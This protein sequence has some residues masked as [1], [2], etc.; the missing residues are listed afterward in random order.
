M[1]IELEDLDAL[2]IGAAILGTGGGGDPYIGRL[3]LQNLIERTGPPSVIELDDLADDAFVITV[4]MSGSPSVMLEKLVD[5]SFGDAALRRFERL[6]G[7]RADAVMPVEIGGLNSLIPLMTSCLT[8]LPV[9]NGDGMGRA[10]PTLDRTSFGIAG[11]SAFPVVTVNERAEVAIVEASSHERGERIARSALVAMGA[12]GSCAFYP[13]TGREAKQTAVKGTLS[14]AL[15]LGRAVEASRAA[16]ADPFDAILG[17]AAAASPP[18]EGR[19]LFQGKISDIS[20]QTV[21]GYNI[22]SGILSPVDGGEEASF[23]FQNEFTHIRQGERLLAVVPDLISFLD[24]ETAQPITCETI[25][26]GQRV[27]VMGFSAAPHFR[28]PDGLAAT[29]PASFG[30][31]D[32]YVPIEALNPL[33]PGNAA[34]PA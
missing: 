18:I 10:F 34:L 12:S 33:A 32:D 20:R 4:G 19:L 22:G 7:R 11:I 26:Y 27:T 31:A 15:A 2:S 14:L 1:N 8:R 29:G 5:H 24:S 6:V 30:L 28:T 9:I 25:R 17:V 13:M 3:A 23:S 16:K 21:G